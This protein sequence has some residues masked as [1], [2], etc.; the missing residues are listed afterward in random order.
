M[1]HTFDIKDFVNVETDQS[2]MDGLVIRFVKRRKES[3]LTQKE[4]SRRSGVSYGSIRRFESTGDISLRSLLRMSSTIGCL[5]D[6]D[7]LF[8]H[9]II[10]N[11]KDMK[12]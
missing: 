8:E 10:K 1:K 9:E 7:H 12:G 11:I 3:E 2:I 5:K 4:L 6:F